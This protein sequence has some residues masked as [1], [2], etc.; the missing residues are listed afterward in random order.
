MNHIQALQQMRRLVDKEYQFRNR[1]DKTTEDYFTILEAAYET[2]HHIVEADQQ[3]FHFGSRIQNRIDR[4]ELTE[5][6]SSEEINGYEIK[7][8]IRPVKGKEHERIQ[9]D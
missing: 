7:V 8:T 2:I 1:K 4:G 6:N 5:Y 9:T 3:D